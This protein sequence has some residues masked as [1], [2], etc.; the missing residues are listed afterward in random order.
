MKAPRKNSW[1]SETLKSDYYALGNMLSCNMTIEKKF[2]VE[3]LK[4]K[5]NFQFLINKNTKA[6]TTINT[7]SVNNKRRRKYLFLCGTIKIM[8]VLFTQEKRK[9]NIIGISC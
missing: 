5:G 1:T 2:F 6:V 9:K 3:N 7:Y 8:L 4:Q